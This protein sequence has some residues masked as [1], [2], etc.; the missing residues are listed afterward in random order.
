MLSYMIRDHVTNQLRNQTKYFIPYPNPGLA[1]NRARSLQHN[2]VN[3]LTRSHWT[4]LVVGHRP[5]PML[6]FYLNQGLDV[7]PI[8]ILEI[9]NYRQKRV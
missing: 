1:P 4:Y 8:L 3:K 6:G 5:D 7:L 2:L 9:T